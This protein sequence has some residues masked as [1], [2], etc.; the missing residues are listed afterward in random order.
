MVLS[1]MA[2]GVLSS[3][4]APDISGAG[5]PPVRQRY[6]RRAPGLSGAGLWCGVDRGGAVGHTGLAVVVP[7]DRLQAV[8]ADLL[9]GGHLGLVT[10]H[11]DLDHLSAVVVLGEHLDRPLGLACVA[12]YLLHVL[13]VVLARLRGPGDLEA[14]RRRVEQQTHDNHFLPQPYSAA[15]LVNDRNGHGRR[16]AVAARTRLTIFN[17]GCYRRV[18]DPARSR[19]G[20]RR[21]GWA[22][23]A[24]AEAGS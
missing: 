2:A 24:S 13:A 14:H 11:R 5:L 3:C 19:R 16:I 7:G 12:V 4:H 8:E 20:S 6:R 9:T 10:S 23:I 22:G 17:G 15:N 21:A 1:V 18:R